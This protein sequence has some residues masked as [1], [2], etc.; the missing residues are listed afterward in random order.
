MEDGPYEKV[1]I[2]IDRR[3][4]TKTCRSDCSITAF[5]E[6]AFPVG[7]F[8]SR[9]STFI[10]ERQSGL[11]FMSTKDAVLIV[12]SNKVTS[13]LATVGNGK[14]GPHWGTWVLSWSHGF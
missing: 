4:S 9:F 7:E 6:Q 5:S 14:Q 3:G 8:P 11:V 10:L 12:G 13:A 2:E 1:N